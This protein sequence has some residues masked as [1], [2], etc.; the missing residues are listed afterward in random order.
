M[1]AYVKEGLHKIQPVIAVARRTATVVEVAVQLNRR[2][3]KSAPNVRF[4][5]NIKA[6]MGSAWRPL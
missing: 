3:L 6:D 5:E 1:D 2:V 4:L